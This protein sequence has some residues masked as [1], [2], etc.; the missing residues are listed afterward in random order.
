M[1]RIG[2][3]AVLLGWALSMGVLGV[4][5]QA[6]AEQEP[7]DWRAWGAEQA[8]AAAA[9]APKVL[10][11]EG[12]I[13]LGL[14][15][16]SDLEGAAA[17]AM[18]RLG[19]AEGAAA[20]LGVMERTRGGLMNAY[21]RSWAVATRAEVMAQLGRMDEAEAELERAEVATRR[22]MGQAWVG[23]AAGESGDRAAMDAAL[24]G[25]VEGM[26]AALAAANEDDWDESWLA[27]EVAWLQSVAGDA[28]G[29]MVLAAGLEDEVIAYELRGLAGRVLVDAGRLA[30]ARAVA[31]S[32]A[33]YMDNAEAE[34]RRQGLE[35]GDEGFVDVDLIRYEMIGLWAGIGQMERAEA[36]RRLYG[37]WGPDWEA[38]GW[39]VMAAYMREPAQAA[40]RAAAFRRAVRLVKDIESEYDRAWSAR[41]IGEAIGMSGDLGAARLLVESDDRPFVK[42]MAHA[43]LAWGAVMRV[44][45]KRLGAGLAMG[46]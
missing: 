45:P 23:V 33:V 41:L 25:F 14:V 21:D 5:G 17:S 16:R 27:Y 8:R 18:V 31:D 29:I 36:E 32:V 39:A 12:E 4:S 20:M 15:S 6:W 13:E 10:F 30:E 1:D 35:V 7:V 22:L 28:D 9:L 46:R 37:Q 38:E 40:E 42:G 26:P 24:K 11:M 2:R 19:D 34:N 44:G 3:I 43:G